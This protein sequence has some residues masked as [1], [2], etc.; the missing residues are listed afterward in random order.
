MKKTIALINGI[1]IVW[2]TKMM[3]LK[4]LL[5][6]KNKELCMEET[7]LITIKELNSNVIKILIV[8]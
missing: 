5:K 4:K 8:N 1:S 6:D 7:E 3:S 2:I